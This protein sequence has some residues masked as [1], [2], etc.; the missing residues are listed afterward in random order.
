MRFDVAHELGHLVLHPAAACD[1]TAQEREANEFASE[2]LIPGDAIPEYL[3]SN[4]PISDLLEVRDQ[5]KVS[6]TALAHATHAAG[7][8]TDWAYRNTCIELSGRGFRKGEPGGMPNHEMSRVF[9]QILGT[10]GTVTARQVA[11]ELRVPVQEV[12]ALT[13]GVEL[14]AAAAGVDAPAMNNAATMSHSQLRLV[15]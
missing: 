3:R 6:A 12:R 4:P 15:R 5:F 8:M 14:G 2:F 13:F 7:R 9:P 11:A 1:D 10:R